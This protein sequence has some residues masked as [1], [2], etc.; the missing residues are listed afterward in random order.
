MA[1]AGRDG[2][3]LVPNEGWHAHV[4]VGMEGLRA[5]IMPTRTWACHPEHR[6]VLCASQ[7]LAALTSPDGPAVPQKD[8]PTV[9]TGM[10]IA[11]SRRIRSRTAL[12]AHRAAAMPN[13]AV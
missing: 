8:S 13:A 6:D 5:G 7:G 10:S 1:A 3:P 12:R 2:D 4:R 11:Y 9:R